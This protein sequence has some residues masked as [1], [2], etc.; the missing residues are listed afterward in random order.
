MCFIFSYTIVLQP[1]TV[2][3]K[4][5]RYYQTLSEKAA[6]QASKTSISECSK[7]TWITVL[8]RQRP[9]P[10]RLQIPKLPH[11]KDHYKSEFKEMLC[12]QVLSSIRDKSCCF[13]VVSPPLERSRARSLFNGSALFVRVPVSMEIVSIRG[14]LQ[15]MSD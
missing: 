2:N 15:A 1:F 11:L 13:V 6:K 7:G 12:K 9:D 3:L 4:F 14:Q 5:K 10:Y 8:K